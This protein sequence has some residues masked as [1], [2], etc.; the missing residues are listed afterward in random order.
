MKP[1]GA[2]QR[3]FRD[4]SP[5]ISFGKAR[6]RRKKSEPK[7][8]DVTSKVKFNYV[9]VPEGRGQLKM[10]VG[11]MVKLGGTMEPPVER[12]T[13]LWGAALGLVAMGFVISLWFG[14]LMSV[15]FEILGK[16]PEFWTNWIGGSFVTGLYGVHVFGIAGTN[17]SRG[18]RSWGVVAISAFWLS[19]LGSISIRLLVQWITS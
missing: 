12:K 3:T 15:L 19:V 10:K 5:A 4:P 18:Y 9:E 2:S 14:M 16:D 6:N 11:P 7:P 8:E 13:A 1:N 17:L